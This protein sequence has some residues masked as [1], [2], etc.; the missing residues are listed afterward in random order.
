MLFSII[1]NKQA[2]SVFK[3]LLNLASRHSMLVCELF[4]D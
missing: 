1:L 2:D 4:L 3:A